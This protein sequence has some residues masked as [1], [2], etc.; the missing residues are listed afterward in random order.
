MQVGDHVSGGDVFGTVYENSL[1][2]NH[3]IMVSPRAMGTVTW[4][5]EKGSYNVDVSITSRT[6][7]F[8]NDQDLPK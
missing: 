5:A 7:P 4:V 2:D 8:P 6:P 1:V 3:R